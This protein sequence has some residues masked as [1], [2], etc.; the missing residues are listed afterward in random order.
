MKE[1]A[2]NYFKEGYSCS[3]SVLKAAADEKLISEHLL[4]VGTV[5]S[6]GISSGCLCG[7]AAAGEIIIGALKGRTDISQS[8]MEAKALA[9]EFLSKFKQAYGATCCRV[10]S[11]KFD[12]NSPER[13][14]HCS[15]MVTGAAEILEELLQLKKSETEKV[16]D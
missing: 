10:L 9:K 6:G 12:F 7:A 4:P 14:Q 8:P 15:R 2:A 13:K 16:H 1:R 5:F 3:E 11:A